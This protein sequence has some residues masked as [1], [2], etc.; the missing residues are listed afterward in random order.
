MSLSKEARIGLL[1]GISVAVLFVGF[2]FLKGLNVFSG[3]NE[4][5]C[6]YE[7]VQGLQSS[8]SIQIRGVS[9][10]RVSGTKL[11]DNKGVRV[12]LSISKDV[13]LPKGTVANLAS[14]DFIT[15]AK[16]IELTLG[17]SSQI[18]ENRSTLPAIAAHGIVDNLSAQLNPLLIDI[19]GM[20]RRLD[21]TLMSV[22]SVLDDQGQQNLSKS[23]ASLRVATDN[24]AILSQKLNGE[25]GTIDKIV[26]NVN[27]VTTNIA[28]NNENITRF[29]SN[30]TEASEKLNKAPI[31]QSFEELE[32]TMKQLQ[33]VVGK[34]NSNQGTLGL[35]VND[36][37]LYNNLNTS[38]A[39]LNNLIVDVKSHPTH[40]INV[41]IFGKK[42]N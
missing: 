6:F 38:L 3:E 7:D 23:I 14:A 15:G 27:K 31:K 34:I 17:N 33:A 25:T 24:I 2:Y 26:G 10:G 4:Y 40:Y 18:L 30:A 20:V 32:E 35:L 13:L 9:V 12:T 16:V 41:T 36:K 11:I 22:N 39:S 1:V 37:E 29:I 5:Y 8:A 28:A 42:K 21:T 19:R